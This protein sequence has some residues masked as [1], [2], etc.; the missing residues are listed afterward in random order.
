MSNRDSISSVISAPPARA[1]ERHSPKQSAAVV[2]QEIEAAQ[3]GRQ[4]NGLSSK[5]P[6]GAGASA[7]GP[8]V[9][10]GTASA[11][12]Q[13]VDDSFTLHI[14]HVS[15]I[16]KR[17]YTLAACMLTLGLELHCWH[18]HMTCINPKVGRRLQLC[19]ATHAWPEHAHD[20]AVLVEAAGSRHQYC[21][22]GCSRCQQQIRSAQLYRCT[23]Q[24]A[25]HSVCT[26]PVNI[27]LC[28]ATLRT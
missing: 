17:T 4:A 19:A 26:H 27:A 15:S 2:E 6:K 25:M 8:G 23:E 14:A 11:G 18:C 22:R 21:N 13:Q 28:Y 20:V 16:Y 12:G 3:K 5:A 1:S 9:A 24:I 7:A 10:S